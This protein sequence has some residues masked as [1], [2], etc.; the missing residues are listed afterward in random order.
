MLQSLQKSIL[1][2]VFTVVICCG[3]YPL[4]LWV[5]G[6][7]FFPSQANGS[8]L[9]DTTGSPVGS[10]LI[11]QSFT[12]DE[13]FQQRPSAASYNAA[14]SSSSALAA[15]NP[16]LRKRVTNSL[17]SIAHQNRVKMKEVPADMVTTSASGLDPH[18]TMQNALFQLDRVADKWAS[19]LK[20][21]PDAIKNEIAQLLDEKS[22]APLGGLVGEKIVNVLEINLELRNRYGAAKK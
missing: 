4:A 20:R 2:L 21:D 5:V 9:L 6:Q 1:L 3:I 17:A 18:I 11:A 16:A 22:L 12:K 19:T 8:I 10:L 13:Y 14:A 15:S 7:T